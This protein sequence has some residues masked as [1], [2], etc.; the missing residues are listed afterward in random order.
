VKS[1]T[2][3]PLKEGEKRKENDIG[4]DVEIYAARAKRER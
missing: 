3:A 4:M 1:E 2:D